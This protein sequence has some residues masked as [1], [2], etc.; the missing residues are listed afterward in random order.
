M[1]ET[2]ELTGET[3]ED[4]GVSITAGEQAV[5]RIKDRVR[6]TF[7]REVIGDIGGFGGL[8]ALDKDRYKHPVLVSSTD[9]VGTKA[10]VAQATNRFDTIGLDLVAMCVDDIVCQGAEPLFFLDY[11]AVGRLDPD[12]IEQLVHGVAEGCLQAGCALI[13]GEM[14][15]HPGAMEPGE[16]DL[17]G[18]AVGVV[19][20]DRI[21]TGAHLSPGD[22]LIGLPSP[23]LRS[24]GYA[25]ARRV[26]LEIG[27]KPLDGPAWD[28]ARDRT[29]A[30]E[31]LE[32]S[33][34]YAPAIT[35]LL[36]HVDVHAIAHITGGGI[37][38]NVA[39]VLG[40]HTDAVV[41]RREWEVPRIFS[42]IQ[43]IGN[44][45][46]E[47]MAKVFNLG[48]GMVIAVPPMDAYKAL[49]RLR[50]SGHRAVEIGQITDGAG[51]V[52]LQA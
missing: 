33:V 28:G 47:E 18:F 7:R 46:D 32:P 8:F 17:V 21:I 30:D 20:R 42:E 13:G 38:G 43:H 9:G 10:F 1:D 48:I 37:V 27:G 41:R 49:D 52:I 40:Q 14:A 22:V 44:V 19:E 36:R 35:D 51:N 45:S 2:P 25:L 3:Y 26:L 5:Q 23:G 4:A 34:I 12:H 16:F 50:E 29:L 15:E 24:N 39:R 31:L 6:Q 11:I